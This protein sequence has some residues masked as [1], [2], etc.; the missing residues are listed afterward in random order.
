MWMSEMNQQKLKLENKIRHQHKKFTRLTFFVMSLF[1]FHSSYAETNVQDQTACPQRPS[2]LTNR[3]QENWDVL[4]NSCVVK[5]TGDQFKYIPFKENSYISLGANIRERFEL[6]NSAKFGT[7]KNSNDQYLIQRLQMHVDAR[8]AEQWQIFAQF[9]DA[10]AYD[11]NTVGSTDQNRFD[12][13]QAFIAWQHSLN[14]GTFKFRV[15]RQEMAFDLQRFISNR[16]GPNV[17]QAFDGVWADY[18]Y[19]DWR[20]LGYM[21]RPVQID[22]AGTLN[23]FSD[24]DL[25]FSGFRIDKQNVLGGE[26]SGYYSRYVR[27][28]ATF[29]SVSGN[30]VR[31]LYDLRHMGSKNNLDWD[32]EAMLQYGDIAD[33]SIQA[34]ALSAITAYHLKD[35]PY[36]PKLAVQIDAASGDKN[37]HDGKLNTFNQL[38]ANGSYFTLAGYSGYSNL[39]HIKPSITIQPNDQL[40]LMAA[41]G[42]QWRQTTQDAIYFQGNSSMP[43]TAGQGSKW[44]GKYL[45]LRADQKVNSN[46]SMAVEAVHYDVGKTILNAGGKDANYLGVEMKYGW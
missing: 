20:F 22:M 6:N 5:K 35:Q 33:Q 19:Q 12:L 4:K 44:T 46:L 37:P 42:L 15:G 25:R 40:T 29:P 11:K 27:N 17:R 41:L 32:V 8:L 23:D 39:I 16:E 14:N 38:F 36:S 7:A 45:Q 3:W 13:E 2:I 9:I 43:N 26:L 21:T 10:R 24:H 18:E 1:Y 28:H 34:W 30:E 31:D